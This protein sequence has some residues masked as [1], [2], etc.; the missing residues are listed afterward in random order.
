MCIPLRS[1]SQSTRSQLPTIQTRLSFPISQGTILNKENDHRHLCLWETPRILLI[2]LYFTTITTT[3]LRRLPQCLLHL[4]RQ[5][6][7]PHALRPSITAFWTR[8]CTRTLRR[9]LRLP[10]LLVPR[11][12][13]R[14]IQRS[15]TMLQ[16]PLSAMRQWPKRNLRPRH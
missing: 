5:S 3:E 6:R 1:P 2:L 11:F 7:R 13:E 12:S 16:S 14:A 8:V 15:I 9:S 10:R 4:S